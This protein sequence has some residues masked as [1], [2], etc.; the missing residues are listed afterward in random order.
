MWYN[1]NI[2]S[3]ERRYKEMGKYIQSEADIKFDNDFEEAQAVREKR[4]R[5]VA[6]M[7]NG[8]VKDEGLDALKGNEWVDALVYNA[9]KRGITNASEE[10]LME[11]F[12]NEGLIHIDK[13]MKKLDK[14]ARNNGSLINQIISMSRDFD[15]DLQGEM[16]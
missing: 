15:S 3:I 8:I 9:Q 5:W 10:M 13:D 11:R 12:E 16:A 14:R 4:I 1:R 6:D 2:T 7:L